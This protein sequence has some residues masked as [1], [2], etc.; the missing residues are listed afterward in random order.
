MPIK[1]KH[2]HKDKNII[3]HDI[4][5]DNIIPNTHSEIYWTTQALTIEIR[6][7]NL[8]KNFHINRIQVGRIVGKLARNNKQIVTKIIGG[9]LYFQFI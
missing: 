8:D 9:V 2:V 5:F 4:I 7:H 3:I 1:T 6:K